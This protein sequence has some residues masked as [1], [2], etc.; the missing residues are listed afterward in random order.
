MQVVHQESIVRRHTLTHGSIYIGH[1]RM[2][3]KR[4]QPRSTRDGGSWLNFD[5]NKAQK[6]VRMAEGTSAI[7]EDDF[8]LAVPG[9]RI[10]VVEFV[11]VTRLIAGG[12][13]SVAWDG[14]SEG[15]DDL[16]FS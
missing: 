2:T 16:A 9:F 10:G 12:I 1:A 11:A 3:I 4:R 14:L 15:E 5:Y 13:V 8:C 6:A 7:G